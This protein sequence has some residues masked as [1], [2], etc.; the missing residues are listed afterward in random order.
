MIFLFVYTLDSTS[1]E[2][3]EHNNSIDLLVET[4]NKLGNTEVLNGK[5]DSIFKDNAI[6]ME[7]LVENIKTCDIVGNNNCAELCVSDKQEE[8][9]HCCT[10]GNS[11]EALHNLHFS[12]VNDI[13]LV[14]K[15]KC[16]KKVY[17]FIQYLKIELEK[18]ND[19]LIDQPVVKH[20]AYLQIEASR[21]KNLEKFVTEY[22]SNRINSPNPFLFVADLKTFTCSFDQL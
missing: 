10:N 14:E 3:N 15:E 20:V 21:K 16:K 4:K 17:Q 12:N 13:D 2:Y 6:S 19:F 9:N 8:F 22:E 1:V 11:K 7:S 5:Q 18:F